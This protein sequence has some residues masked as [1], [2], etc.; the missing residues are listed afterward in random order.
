MIK[1]N[2]FSVLNVRTFVSLEVGCSLFV[3]YSLKVGYSGLLN[4]NKK[5]YRTK[6]ED[7]MN[8][9]YE[10]SERKELDKKIVKTDQIEGNEIVDNLQFS[11]Y[12]SI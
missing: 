2:T 7:I 5:F 1:K 4:T 12:D 11:D 9:N 3:S 10:L 6:N 8:I